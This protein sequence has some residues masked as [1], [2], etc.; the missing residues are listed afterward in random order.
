MHVTLSGFVLF[1][2]I[3]VAIAAFMIAGVLHGALQALARARTTTEMRPWAAAVHRLEPL[4]PISALAL[5]VLGAWLVH[6]EHGEG[7]RWSDGW[8]ITAVVTLIVV[9]GAAGALLAPRTK[10]LVQ[11]IHDSA[12]GGVP[13][14]VHDA[15]LDPVIWH[16]AHVATVGFLG[17]V[18]LMAAKPSGAWAPVFPIAGALLGIAAS[19]AQLRAITAGAGRTAHVPAPRPGAETPAASEV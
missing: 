1:L 3:A 19:R 15:T 10:K 14:D 13:Q 17:V 12:D 6:L 2:H 9:E 18:F 11:R 4:L 5:L 8:V 16:I 7:L